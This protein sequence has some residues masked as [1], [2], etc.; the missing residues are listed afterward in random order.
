MTGLN[1]CAPN[2]SAGIELPPASKQLT[3]MT[4]C[5]NFDLKQL[6]NV[7]IPGWTPK[8]ALFKAVR[9]V[10]ASKSGACDSARQLNLE[11][12]THLSGWK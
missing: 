9:H 2:A 1:S 5:V 12:L 6:S 3:H 7:S 4:H 8:T 10:A 11:Q